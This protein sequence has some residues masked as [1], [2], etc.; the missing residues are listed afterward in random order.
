MLNNWYRPT[1]LYGPGITY[2]DFK[3]KLNENE[4]PIFEC[5]GDADNYLLLTTSYF[6]SFCD[7]KEHKVKIENIV[8][9]DQTENIQNERKTRTT[10][11]EQIKKEIKNI[12]G[13]S[14]PFYIEIGLSE[15][16]LNK[17]LVELVWM[18]NKFKN[19]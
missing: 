14:I 11:I 3:V 17:C 13:E 16:M 18:C 1:K 19:E 2:T 6:Y 12:H 7:N 8:Y 15:L 5:S 9:I 4:L 10:Y